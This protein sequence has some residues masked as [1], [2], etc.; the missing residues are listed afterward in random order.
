MLLDGAFKP[1]G[2]WMES[3]TAQLAPILLEGSGYYVG[4]QEDML[5]PPAPAGQP[6]G[7]F[8]LEGGEKQLLVRTLLP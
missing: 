5:P 7:W 4:P 6:L 1:H 8:I 3:L 2:T